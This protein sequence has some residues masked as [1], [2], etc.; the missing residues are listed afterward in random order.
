VSTQETLNLASLKMVQ[1]EL[2]ATIEQ[3]AMRLEQ[4]THDRANG[5]LLQECIDGIKQIRG[6]LSL[7]QLKGVD[8]LAE[9]LLEHITDITLDAAPKNDRKLELLSAAFFILPRY[10]EY[11]TQTS[12][13][14]AMLLIPYINELRQARRAAPLPE[15]YYYPFE[16]A[17]LTHT[18]KVAALPPSENLTA[19]VRRLRHMYQTGLLKVVKEEQVKPSLGIMARALER[20]EGL[21]GATQL[22]ALWWL[23]GIFLQ[24]LSAQGLQLTK[25]RK[26]VLS[27]LDRE[28]R[29]LHSGG[30]VA[31]AEPVDPALMK[32]LVYLIALSTT[33]DERAQAALVFY[34]APLPGFSEADL[35]REM[36]FLKGPSANTL[37]SM[38]AVLSDE[39]R[40]TKNI[41]ERAAQGGTELLNESP[42]LLDTLKKVAEILGVV[43]LVSPAESLKQEIERI[44]QWQQTNAQISAEELLS[45]ADTL[46]YVESAIAGLGK[47]SLSDE[48]LAQINALSRDDVMTNSQIAEAEHLV[49]EEAESG[50][51]MVKRALSAFME[52][53]YDKGHIKNILATLDTVRGGMFVLG[54]PRAAKVV[55][56]CLEFIDES[57]LQGE[58]QA[59]VQHMLET[60]ADAIISLE[61]YLDSIKLDKNAD[62]S[63]LQIAEE[64]LEA[65][66]YKIA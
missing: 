8:V 11:C 51:A 55:A 21:C 2:V 38:A 29:R 26:L 56:A 62:T 28:I 3:A 22:S 48:K 19:V 24:E 50:L 27:A 41:L 14:M 53:N 30:Q 52:S 32:E 33:K 57:L 34:S 5:E 36:E 45:V 17:Q 15:S 60:F 10:L 59:A 58:Q 1:D 63:V 13:S 18:P 49:I 7:I 6:T 4:F 35:L 43:G 25:S 20:L 40:S 54:L 37:N 64:S 42:E 44:A 12:R 23:A 46:L 66:G 61:Y 65:L 47:I 39:L 31:I 9:E 16:P